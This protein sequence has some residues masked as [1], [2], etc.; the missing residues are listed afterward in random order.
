MTTTGKRGRPDRRRRQDHW[1]PHRV[2]QLI[3]DCSGIVCLCLNDETLDTLAL[4]PMT[5]RNE[6]RHG[7]AFTV[8]IEA[9]EG[10]STGVSARD[11][12]TTIR[13]AIAPHA[14]AGDVVSPGHV[15]PLRAQPGG[16]LSA[17][18]PHG[19][20]RRPRHPGRAAPG[21][22]VLCELMNDDG[23]MARGE[24]Y[25]PLRREA[26][27]GRPDHRGTGRLSPQPGSP[28]R[29]ADGTGIAGRLAGGRASLR[30]YRGRL[31]VAKSR[32]AVHA[33]GCLQIPDD[34]RQAGVWHIAD[35][36]SRAACQHQVEIHP[37]IFDR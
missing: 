35:D 24:S 23:T 19:R 5:A 25:R 20:L 15:F 16:V 17:A 9:R 6:S 11:R 28:G 3:R 14:Q 8:S 29:H 31:P 32:Q 37:E 33:T 26:R 30:R 12:V 34:T 1:F 22:A 27:P 7:T 10:V 4:P 18:R 36:N 2:A 21:R 13:A